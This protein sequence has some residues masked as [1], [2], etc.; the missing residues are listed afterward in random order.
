LIVKYL[1]ATNDKIL[2]TVSDKA[3]ALLL[4]ENS[5]DRWIDIY[6]LRKGQ[7]TPKRGQ[8][9]WDFESDVP[10]KYTKGGIVYNQTDKNNDPKGWSAL[11]IKRYNELFEIV[12]KDRKTHKTF[13]VNW[14]VKRR[15]KLLEAVQSR[16]RKRPQKQARKEKK[17]SAKAS[18]N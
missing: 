17:T 10:T 1:F 13:T 15:A 8:K 9:R 5:F 3:S 14:L 7:V 4:L 18:S 6:C 12:R 2:C 16:K 11:G